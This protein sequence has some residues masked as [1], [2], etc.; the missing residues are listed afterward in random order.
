MIIF[1]LLN[2]LRYLK[3]QSEIF[4]TMKII[5]P[6]T[7]YFQEISSTNFITLCRSPIYLPTYNYQNSADPLAQ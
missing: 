7:N 2:K 6:E 5:T 4:L 1:I 3:T